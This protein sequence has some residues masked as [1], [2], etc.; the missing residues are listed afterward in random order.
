MQCPRGH[1]CLKGST[2]PTICPDGKVNDSLGGVDEN[3]CVACQTGYYC[4]QAQA[5]I[6]PA[7]HYCDGN[8]SGGVLDPKECP[9]DTY[10][11]DEG[12]GSSADCLPCPAGNYCNDKAI[13]D[14]DFYKCP[15]GKYCPDGATTGDLVP[16]IDCPSGYYND[17]RGLGADTECTQ[18]PGGSYCAAGSIFPLKCKAGYYCPAGSSVGVLCE[19]GFY[20]P[21]ESPD[22]VQCPQA[23]YCPT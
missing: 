18:C 23:Y 9:E 13:A 6:C 1:Y 19:P 12:K 20:C 15:K 10:N 4:I 17:R 5:Y 14:L 2:A 8:N 11:P 22:H 3:A 16:A 7:G 21:Y